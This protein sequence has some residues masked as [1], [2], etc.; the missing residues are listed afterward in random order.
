M[1]PVAASEKTLR[2]PSIAF[3]I[4]RKSEFKPY[5]RAYKPV[6]YSPSA[7]DIADRYD[8]VIAEKRESERAF[9]ENKLCEHKMLTDNENPPHYQYDKTVKAREIR[10]IDR[11]RSEKRRRAANNKPRA[12]YLAE[13]A[14]ATKAAEARELYAASVPVAK[15]VNRL[16]T[17]PSQ[18]YR[19][20]K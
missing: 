3:R 2:N 13:T 12:T 9:I 14:T 1:E 11:D 7:D 16:K 8:E 19:W 6:C 4:Y 10:E 15:I 5:T 20:I 18:V 17:S